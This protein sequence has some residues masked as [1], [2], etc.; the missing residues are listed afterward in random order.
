M[1]VSYCIKNITNKPHLFS[2]KKF[3]D[4]KKKRLRLSGR[5]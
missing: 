4:T 2:E 5:C 1:H 3:Y